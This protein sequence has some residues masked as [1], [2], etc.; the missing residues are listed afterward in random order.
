MTGFTPRSFPDYFEL[1]KAA[2]LTNYIKKVCKSK[3]TEKGLPYNMSTGDIAFDAKDGNLD[4]I[5]GGLFGKLDNVSEV[6]SSNKQKYIDYLNT[7]RDRTGNSV[8]IKAMVGKDQQE[9]E[10]KILNAMNLFYE[11]M[12]S[13]RKDSI[14]IS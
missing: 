4:V 8:N 3:E 7:T 5:S 10:L 13:D 14:K 11:K 2:S 9:A 6:L 12:P 1:F